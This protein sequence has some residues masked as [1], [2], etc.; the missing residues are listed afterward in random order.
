CSSVSPEIGPTIKL[1]VFILPFDIELD[2]LQN[3]K[4]FIEKAKHL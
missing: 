4:K 2:K 1:G 3:L